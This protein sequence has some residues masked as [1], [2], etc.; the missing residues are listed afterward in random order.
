MKIENVEQGKLFVDRVV[1]K[2]MKI[3]EEELNQKEK[4]ESLVCIVYL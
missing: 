4:Y 3:L 1:D 2:I